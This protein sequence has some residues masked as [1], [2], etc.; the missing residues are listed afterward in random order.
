M[1]VSPASSPCSFVRLF[2]ARAR[3]ASSRARLLSA[4]FCGLAALSIPAV[5]AA[6]AQT[7][8]F[9]GAQTAVRGGLNQPHGV[10]VDGSGN[11]YI[12]DGNN[13]RVVRETPS[14]GGY[15][16][17]TVANQA[18]NGL[19]NPHG[20]A[21]DGAG[22]VYIADTNNNRVLMETLSGGT[23]TQTI[24]GSGLSFPYGVAVDGGGDV[25]IADSFN[26]RVLKETLSGGT[27]TQTAIGSGLSF[28]TGVAADGNGN[29][30]IVDTNNNR[31][32]EVA[33]AGVNFHSVKIGASSISM[34]LTFTFDTA[35][36]LS[37]TPKLLTAGAPNLDFTDA[38]TG[39][40]T[41]DGAG[42]PYA[43]GDSCTVDVVFTPKFAGPRYGAVVL[44]G[45]DGAAIAT[46][47]VYGAGIGPQVAFLPVNE[48]ALGGGFFIPDGLAVD[49]S[50][51]VYVADEN[52]NAVKEIP[53]GCASD[54]CVITLGGFINAPGGIAVDGAAN[55][56][57]TNAVFHDVEKIPP[58]CT[59]ILCLTGLTGFNSPTT[60]A[61]DGSGNVYVADSGFRGVKEIPSGCTSASCAITLGGG[62][63]SP[64]AVAV[65]G[66]GDVYVADFEN[67]AVKE[68]PPGCTSASCVITLTQSVNAQPAALAVDGGGNI[69]VADWFNSR[70]L[71]EDVVTPPSLS[72]ATTPAN[73]TSSDSPQTVTLENIG[74]A[75]LRFLVPA[76]GMNPR[77]SANFSLDDSSTCPQSDTSSPRAP[78]ASG[79]SCTLP[80]SFT[81]TTAGNPLTGTATITDN[82][83]NVTPST[84]TINL[85]GTA[86]QAT[87]IITFSLI[88]LQGVGHSVRLVAA[89]SSGLP[90]SF[91]SLTPSVCTVSGTTAT[92]IAA[93]TC[94]I[95]ATQ[96][97]DGAYAA[98]TPVSQSFTVTS[99]A[100]FTMTPI[101]GSE[102]ISGVCWPDLFCGLTR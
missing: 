52:H 81:P 40:G 12:A 20:V 76:S 89:A 64:T 33:T 30:S 87:Q 90:V 29:V 18:N 94:T 51:N 70:V 88:P 77:V 42:H 34:S 44:D 19:A 41:T 72:F 14:G 73:S 78:L 97:G 101:P 13:N 84:Q 37:A 74:T 75:P 60:V 100:S 27:Y 2:G 95:Q 68:I 22:N 79:S 38:G 46:A 1:K 62:F 54:S 3:R 57:V 59:S 43:A 7:A 86:T 53:L 36:N 28:P 25:Y 98:A 31:V 23:Y 91:Q 99:A 96:A 45:A 15:I 5:P 47:Y 92:A 10:A 6:R 16:Q 85:N 35:G 65:D 56:W 69:Y 8:H 71:K 80:L 24:I 50:G 58:G 66:G 9:A 102:T 49:G 63:N 32:M 26:N 11:V 48:S 39:T 17:S 55:V 21:V 82:N 61:V 83:L 67:N 4:A 93:A